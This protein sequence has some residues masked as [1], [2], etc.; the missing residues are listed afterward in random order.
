MCGST[1]E[2]PT[3]PTCGD[4]VLLRA[5]VKEAWRAQFVSNVGQTLVATTLVVA[6]RYE[7]KTTA[8]REVDG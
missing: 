6:S 8:S 3:K 7:W 2:A 1:V 4:G 5:R